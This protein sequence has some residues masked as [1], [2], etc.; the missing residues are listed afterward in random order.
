MEAMGTAV[1]TAMTSV[2]TEITKN[3]GQ[4]APVA[5][6]IVGAL[7]VIQFGIRT[8]RTIAG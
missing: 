3:M 5:L 4:V 7:M 8:F 6:G 2:A 1:V